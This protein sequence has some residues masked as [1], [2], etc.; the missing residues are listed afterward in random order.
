MTHQDRAIQHFR[1]KLG[2]LLLVR[3][4]L[5]Y[6][7]V[8]AFLWGTAVLVLRVTL[9]MPQLPLLAGFA[10]LP[11]II[12]AAWWGSWRRLPSGAGVRALLD[13]RGNCGGL[14]MAQEETDLGTW[15]DTLPVLAPPRIVADRICLRGILFESTISPPITNVAFPRTPK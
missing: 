3:Q 6:L 10:G 4:A 5:G 11:L 9:A 1:R 15:Q 7:A 14:L 2:L 13:Q 12:L 8:Y